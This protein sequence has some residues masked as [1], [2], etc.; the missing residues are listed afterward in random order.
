MISQTKKFQ[1]WWQA[2]FF[3]LFVKAASLL[4]V[5]FVLGSQAIFFSGVNIVAPL[6]G[7]FGGVRGSLSVFMLGVTI[8]LLLGGFSGLH[9]L[10]F[11][12][13]GLFAALYW[14]SSSGL[15]RVLVPQLCIILFIAHPVGSLA[16]PYAF[17]WFI[18]IALYFFP[19]N[20]LFF[21]ALGST[22]V[23]HAVGSVIWLYTM[24]TA[25]SLWLSLMPIVV[26]ERLLFAI[27]MVGMYHLLAW[28]VQAW[29]NFVH[30]RLPRMHTTPH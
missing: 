21:Q 26:L 27:G 19:R 7:A 12:V 17:F 25:P 13:P 28:I 22:F 9:M 1:S 10:A 3:T 20:G 16:F 18:P 2:A 24:P 30:I 4:K 23:A 11:C 29:H 5:S 8:Q 15:I 14:A 6:S